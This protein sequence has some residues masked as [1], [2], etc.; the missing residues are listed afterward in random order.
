MTTQPTL[1][2]PAAQ[3]RE[4]WFDRVLKAATLID[5]CSYRDVSLALI[6]GDASLR[7]VA[8]LAAAIRDCRSEE[9]QRHFVGEYSELLQE[10]IDDTLQ[11]NE[12]V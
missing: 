8:K 2:A 3:P 7:E 6:A 4:P 9:S 10:F 5:P 12:A 11:R 1:T